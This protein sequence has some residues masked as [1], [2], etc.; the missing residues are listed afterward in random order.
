M[1]SS[2]TARASKNT[3]QHEVL[4]LKAP[5]EKH[6][7]QKHVA[8]AAD[9]KRPKGQEPAV[10]VEGGSNAPMEGAQGHTRRG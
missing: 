2:A 9:W 8:P 6:T 4:L 3:E 7:N 10:R 5:N 1:A